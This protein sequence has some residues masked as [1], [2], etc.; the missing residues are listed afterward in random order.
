MRRLV[1]I[2]ELVTA[3]EV[4]DRLNVTKS[5]VSKWQERDLGFPAPAGRIG[6]YVDVWLWPEVVAWY[7]RFKGGKKA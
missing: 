6:G 5:A 4:A 1:D 7:R 2:E 3:A